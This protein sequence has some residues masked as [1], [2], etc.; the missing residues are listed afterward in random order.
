M[1]RSVEASP[2]DHDENILI[3]V[4]PSVG[5]YGPT[6]KPQDV[7][8]DSTSSAS[9]KLRP[10]YVL[11]DGTALF[12][13]DSSHSASAGIDIELEQ[14]RPDVSAYALSRTTLVGS[15]EPD[16]IFVVAPD[17]PQMSKKDCDY[18]KVFWDH[19]RNLYHILLFGVPN[20]YK[21]RV[22]QIFREVSYVEDEVMKELVEELGKAQ[23]HLDRNVAAQDEERP[24]QPFLSPMEFYNL[25]E[26]AKL[27][28]LKTLWEGF[29]D[30]CIREWKAGNLIAILL[31]ATVKTRVITSF[32]IRGLCSQCLS[33][34]Y[35]GAYRIESTIS[36][37]LRLNVRS[38]IFYLAGIMLYIWRL[39][40]EIPG[41]T[42]PPSFELMSK[43]TPT[44]V[45]VI[46]IL[47]FAL[48]MRALHQYGSPMDK[49]W[50]ASVK[51]AAGERN[52]N[53]PR[54][55]NGSTNMEV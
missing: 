44:L 34:G 49:R 41:P 18:S 47:H 33:P 48:I 46:G 17:A 9:P 6:L 27:R 30:K 55:P 11:I 40:W 42:T 54:S 36:I 13:S 20:F 14:R 12:S 28:N 5:A 38:L 43:I 26:N 29:I 19:I 25:P 10:Q 4:V 24:H 22:H 16:P 23:L 45:L 15:S 53:I 3:E 2:P 32:G 52:I 37:G 1:D 35:V 50:R 8:I 31:L 7:L 51:M 39:S 21:Y